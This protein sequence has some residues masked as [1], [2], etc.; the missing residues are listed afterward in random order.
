MQG[1]GACPIE[2]QPG[3]ALQAHHTPSAVRSTQ[4][5]FIIILTI[6]RERERERARKGQRER[7]RKGERGERDIHT[8]THTQTERECV[9]V[10]VCVCVRTARSSTDRKMCRT[11]LQFLRRFLQLLFLVLLCFVLFA[12]LNARARARVF[13]STDYSWSVE[14]CK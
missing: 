4:V 6:E 5:L 10:C 11:A 2:K 12:G 14:S 1:S 7:E 8:N 3:L 13:S 9:C